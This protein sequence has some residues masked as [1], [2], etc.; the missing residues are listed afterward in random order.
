MNHHAN[1]RNHRGQKNLGPDALVSS[2]AIIP[3]FELRKR[4]TIGAFQ[5][6]TYRHYQAYYFIR[7]CVPAM[8][9]MTELSG[10]NERMNST[11]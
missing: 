6:R 3:I 2:Y 1:D 10:M 7:S 11:E 5:S 4:V 9:Q 8:E